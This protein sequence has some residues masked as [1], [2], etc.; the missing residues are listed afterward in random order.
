MFHD[1]HTLLTNVAEGSEPSRVA[2]ALHGS[3]A[4][5]VDTSRK[6][7]TFVAQTSGPAAPPT[8]PQTTATNNG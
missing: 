2:V 3:G 8:P 4:P 6:R 5:T 1:A 7:N